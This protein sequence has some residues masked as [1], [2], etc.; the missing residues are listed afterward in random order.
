MSNK[1]EAGLFCL[2]GY[3]TVCGLIGDV[4][5]LIAAL[6][7][8]ILYLPLLPF[9]CIASAICPSKEKDPEERDGLISKERNERENGMDAYFDRLGK[10]DLID[11]RL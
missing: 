4:L 2:E 5:G 8:I 9:V 6:I 3:W 10:D 7:S 11:L 1:L